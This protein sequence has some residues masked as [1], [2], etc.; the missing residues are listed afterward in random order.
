M[1]QTLYY[2]GTQLA[3]KVL[4]ICKRH[5]VMSF[6][7]ILFSVYLYNQATSVLTLFKSIL[8]HRY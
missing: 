8:E 4:F 5:K 7:T 3:L 6:L 2:N 1:K